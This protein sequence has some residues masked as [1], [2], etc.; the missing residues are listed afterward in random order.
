ME[1]IKNI[2]IPNLVPK[3]SFAGI[4]NLGGGG[5]DSL[6]DAYQFMKETGEKVFGKDTVKVTKDVDK[7]NYGAYLKKNIGD[8]PEDMYDPHA[9]YIL[10]K[11]GNRKA[12]KELVKEGQEILREYDIDPIL[13]LENL[14]WAPNRV[15][16]QHG[17]EAL[18]NVIDRLGKIRDNG[19]DRDD[20][21]KELRKLR[22]IA[23]RRI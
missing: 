6:K 9:H 21:V 10:F 2:E 17:I 11:K 1:K 3:T 14:V 13:G 16:G 12:Q 5:L 22:D 23:K 15:K 19:E 7:I 8:P 18:R 20:I 4:G